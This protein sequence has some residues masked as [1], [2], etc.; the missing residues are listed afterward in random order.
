M[1]LLLTLPFRPIT[2]ELTAE[3]TAGDYVDAKQRFDNAVK[4]CIVPEHQNG[5][6]LIS[7]SLLAGMSCKYSCDHPEGLGRAVMK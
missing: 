5:S 6:C 1:I 4:R 2:V 7:S 3:L